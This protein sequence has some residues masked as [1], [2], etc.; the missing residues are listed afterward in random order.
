M[1]FYVGWKPRVGQSPEVGEKSLEVFSRWEPPEGLEFRGMWS[2]ADGG[3]FCVC[4]AASAEVVFEATAPW[5]GSFLDYDI[6][7]IVDMDKA[8]GLLNKAIAFR[9]G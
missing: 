8:V 2:R 9:K 1:L 7:P 4:E 6:V 3:G 5:A